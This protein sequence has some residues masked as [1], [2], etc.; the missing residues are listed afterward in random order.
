MEDYD[1]SGCNVAILTENGF[2]HVELFE[3]ME[4]LKESGATV[5]VLSPAGGANDTVRSWKDGNWGDELRIDVA[6]ADA[7]PDRYDALLIPGGVINPDR[8]RRDED[9][10]E[11]VRSFVDRGKP[12]AAI[13]HAPWMLVEAGV[14]E[15]RRMT[16]Y[17][18]IRTDVINAGAKWVDEEVVVDEGVV[19]SRSPGDLPAFIDKMLEEFH[20]GIHM[21]TGA[22]GV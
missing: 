1:L 7:D 15:G 22:S 13:C 11:F 2:E 16:S 8:L 9:A 12:I 18:S 17:H 21:R 3:P 10:V 14:A 4:A 6:M 5:H 20:E 19:T